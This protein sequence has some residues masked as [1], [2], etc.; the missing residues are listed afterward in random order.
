MDLAYIIYYTSPGD[1]LGEN[2][3]K[4]LLE[5]DFFCIMKLIRSAAVHRRPR[6]LPKEPEK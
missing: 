1:C 4:L 6:Q 3:K 5:K 2:R